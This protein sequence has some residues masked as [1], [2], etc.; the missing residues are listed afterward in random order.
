MK[1]ADQLADSRED[2]VSIDAFKYAHR[3]IAEV[4]ANLI[5]GKVICILCCKMQTEL[6]VY[7]LIHRTGFQNGI[8]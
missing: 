6:I 1:H 3:C 7:I 4:M 2:R 5:F 8:S